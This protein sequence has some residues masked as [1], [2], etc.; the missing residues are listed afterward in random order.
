MN[1]VATVAR[2]LVFPRARS[3]DSP[4]V[5]VHNPTITH[6]PENAKCEA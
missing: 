6:L 4:P 2:T 3:V 5:P 1:D